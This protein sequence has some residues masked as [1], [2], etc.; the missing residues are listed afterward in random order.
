MTGFA[1]LAAA[2][3]T[4]ALGTLSGNADLNFAPSG[5]VKTVPFPRVSASLFVS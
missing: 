2:L 5:A 1:P 4:V 3:P